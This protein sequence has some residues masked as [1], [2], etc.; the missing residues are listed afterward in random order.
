MRRRRKERETCKERMKNE[1]RGD[2]KRKQIA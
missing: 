2:E 1:E